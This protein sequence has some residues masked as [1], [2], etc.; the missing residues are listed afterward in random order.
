MGGAKSEDT[1]HVT[2]AYGVFMLLWL[3]NFVRMVGWTIMAGAF[4]YWYFFS[5]DYP[6]DPNMKS[7]FPILGSVYRT[8]RYH[9]G[10]VAFASL[11]VAICQVAQC[12]PAALRWR[13]VQAHTR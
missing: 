3:L 1:I 10:T 9:L 8:F 5:D 6:A 2:I 7:R 12:A 13:D 4:C 11:V